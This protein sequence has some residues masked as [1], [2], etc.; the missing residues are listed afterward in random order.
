MKKSKVV[1]S[2]LCVTLLAPAI[3]T[4]NS[5][6]S[7]P[8]EV[9]AAMVSS[10]I[11][12]GFRIVVCDVD[13]EPSK[14]LSNALKVY[15]TYEPEFQ[16]DEELAPMPSNMSP[17][18]RFSE[19]I[20]QM[21]KD[22][23][24]DQYDWN[25]SVSEAHSK[26]ENTTNQDWYNISNF[27]AQSAPNMKDEVYDEDN[28]FGGEPMLE[29][30]DYTWFVHVKK[31]PAEDKS[32]PEIPATSTT[33]PKEAPKEDSPKAKLDKDLPATGFKSALAITTIGLTSIL[34]LLSYGIAAKL[35]KDRN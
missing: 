4:S 8:K 21:K 25:V 30:V 33:Q 6:H 2:L 3:L 23:P 15:H 27:N 22:F 9:E 10:Y 32:I 20:E 35:R 29:S 14:D 1:C 18:L 13:S 28:T 12:V 31:K 19:A 5:L 34:S 11:K 7:P 24:E 17:R 26:V 16:P